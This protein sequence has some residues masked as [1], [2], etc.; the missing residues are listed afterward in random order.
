MGITVNHLCS[1]V[2]W[3][4]SP[5]TS[6]Q[7]PALE[8]RP[9]CLPLLFWWDWFISDKNKEPDLKNFWGVRII[10]LPWAWA[11][12]SKFS[13]IN[14]S[15]MQHNTTKFPC[16]LF[17]ITFLI[18]FL[19]HLIYFLITYR[20]NKIAVVEIR[21]WRILK[22]KTAKRL[23]SFLY[24]LKLSFFDGKKIYDQNVYHRYTFV[25]WNFSL[26]PVVF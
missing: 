7:V 19:S 25:Q 12:K 3:I 21:A 2:K 18:V 16:V 5:D 1:G 17:L 26:M 4:R 9:D 6:R 24:I 23:C 8:S 10:K 14:F 22:A 13:K 15:K 11:S 20:G